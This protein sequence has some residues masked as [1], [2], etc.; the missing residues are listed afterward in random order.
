MTNILALCR[1]FLSLLLS[2]HVHQSQ[3]LGRSSYIVTS[4]DMPQA[5]KTQPLTSLCMKW[6]AVIIYAGLES[7]EAKLGLIHGRCSSFQEDNMKVLRL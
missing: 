6:T 5:L 2:L 4:V 1:G 7:M 3:Q